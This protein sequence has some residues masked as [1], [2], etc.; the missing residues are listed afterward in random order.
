MKT[1]E[2]SLE[3]LAH[4]IADQRSVSNF[5]NKNSSKILFAASL[6][7]F[8]GSLSPIKTAVAFKMLNTEQVAF[9]LIQIGL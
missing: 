7:L 4:L 5:I 2:F 3:G 1:Y 6:V 9:K 8:Y